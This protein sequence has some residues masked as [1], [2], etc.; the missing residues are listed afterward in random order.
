MKRAIPAVMVALFLALSVGS[1]WGAE[2]DVKALL[3]KV[4]DI[5]DFS[6]GDFSGLFT[7]VTEKP[8]EKQSV[9]QVR[10]FR[11]DEKDQFLLLILIPEANRGQGYLKEDDNFW[12]YDPTSRKFTHSSV[13]ETITNSEAKNSD[14]TKHKFSVDYDVSATVEGKL[15]KFAV[16]VID[17]K[18]KDNE[19]SY[20]M[21]RLYIRQDQPLV[22][23][24]EDMS[25]SGRLMRTVLYPKYADLGNGKFYPSQ[26]LILD[27]VNKGEKSQLTLAELST[28]KLP[29]KVFTKAFVEQVN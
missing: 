18:A 22:L 28:E 26:M 7:I 25:V 3:K 15:G 4:D 16:W 9:T 23:K 8:G 24:E 20:D 17:L 21:V 6:G 13:K 19:V 1:L 11:R 14:M 2:P 29:D 12:Y 27:E 5:N 10:M